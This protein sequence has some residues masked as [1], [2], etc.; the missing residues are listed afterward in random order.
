MTSHPPD[1]LLQSILQAELDR[2]TRNELI[3]HVADCERCFALVEELWASACN[4]QADLS[5][6]HLD[7]M[8]SRRIESRLFSQIHAASLTAAAS[9]LATTGFLEVTIGLL[10]PILDFPPASANREDGDEP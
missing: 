6:V 8:A 10:R 5:L 2:A 9:R 7:A 4:E 1:E 3:D